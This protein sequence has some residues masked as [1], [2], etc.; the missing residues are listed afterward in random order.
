MNINE[1][2]NSLILEIEKYIEII[3]NE[4]SELVDIP[5]DLDLEGRVHI[6]DTGTISLFVKNKNFYFPL[7]AFEVIESLKNNPLYGSNR[8]HRTCFDDEI[9]LN[10]NTFQ[11]FINHIII[12]GLSVE[13]YYKEI[14]LHETLH[15][16]GSGGWHALREGINELKT[17]QL[18]KKYN[19][20]TSSCAYPKE[21][22]IAYELEQIFGEE[23]INRIAFTKNNQQ[24]KEIL[25]TVSPDAAEFYFALEIKMDFEFQE[26]YMK[27]K[28]PGINGPFEKMKKYNT[29][30]YSKVHEMIDLYKDTH[31]FNLESN[32]VEETHLIK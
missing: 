21:T 13:E 18:A 26:K 30:D 2:K 23:I 1:I 14:L 6:E 10:N 4:Y 15:F 12:K 3:R 19:L 22:K 25:D 24:V 27:H 29:I 17:R 11:D 16:C 20:L 28:F 8:E 5:E 31:G 9:I 7:T 32:L